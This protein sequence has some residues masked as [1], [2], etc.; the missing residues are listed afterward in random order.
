M[1]NTEQKN[2]IEALDKLESDGQTNLQSG[3]LQGLDLIK[4][5][6]IDNSRHCS[7]ILLTDGEPNIFPP[8]GH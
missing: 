2:A 1:T 6:F 4:N 8:S 7:V 5:K 3:L